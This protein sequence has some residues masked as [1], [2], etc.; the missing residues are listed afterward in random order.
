MDIYTSWK[1]WPQ[2]EAGLRATLPE[3]VVARIAEA[4]R[5]AIDAHG[6]QRRPTGVPYLEH[7]L[8]ALEIAVV[9]AGVTDPE[10][11]EAIVL[12]DVVEDTPRTIAEIG[13]RFGQPVAE[14]VAW[15][16]KPPTP[17]GADKAEVKRAYLESLAGA[18]DRAVL[19]K[20]ADRVSN[21][22][23][24]HRMPEDFQARYR[25]ETLRHVVPLAERHP[26][27]RA[28]FAEF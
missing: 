15:V 1:T 14:L 8:E 2:A 19:V 9:G 6:E 7:L 25:S 27:F 5:F 4:A 10:V 3:A 24:L 21:V 23:E 22:Q 13:D 11:L 26:W 17:P 12:H 16:T 18:P 20:L 28:W